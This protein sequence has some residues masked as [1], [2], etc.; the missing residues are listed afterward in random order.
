MRDSYSTFTGEHIFSIIYFVESFVSYCQPL[1]QCHAVPSAPPDPVRLSVVT[2]TA[3]TVQWEMVPCV[4]R[5]GDITGYLVQYIGGGATD[6]KSVTGDDATMT[7]FEG[8]M[9]STT[10]SIVIAA[11]NDAGTGDY[12]NSMII[13]T[14]QSK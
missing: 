4:H 9:P 2:S 13:E 10:Y 12:S 14:P 1:T 7:T 6:S 3:I 11:V 8:L 5:N